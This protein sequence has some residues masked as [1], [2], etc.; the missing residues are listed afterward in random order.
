M[1]NKLKKKSFV[2]IFGMIIIN[3]FKVV[4]DIEEGFKKKKKKKNKKRVEEKESF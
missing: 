2:E 1:S 3:K 4:N